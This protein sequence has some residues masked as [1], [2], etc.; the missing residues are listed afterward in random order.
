[1]FQ[2]KQNFG[3]LIDADANSIAENL[4]L[5][6]LFLFC[7]YCKWSFE[8]IKNNNKSRIRKLLLSKKLLPLLFELLL[9]TGFGSL[10]YCACLSYTDSWVCCIEYWKAFLFPIWHFKYKLII[11]L[12]A[13]VLKLLHLQKLLIPKGFSIKTKIFPS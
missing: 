5:P 4:L 8:Q 9:I 2:R 3:V 1:M 11:V 6:L 13:T 12:K 7:I 10:M